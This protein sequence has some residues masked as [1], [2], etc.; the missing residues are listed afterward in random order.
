MAS[1]ER[2][3]CGGHFSICYFSLATDSLGILYF[4]FRGW[5]GGR[6]VGATLVANIANRSKSFLSRFLLDGNCSIRNAVHHS[7]MSCHRHVTRL[8]NGPG[9]RLRCTSLNSSV[10]LVRIIDGIHPSRVCGLTTR[11]R[12][13]IDFSTPR[14][15][16]GMSTAN[17]LHVLR[18]M[19]L[20]KLTSAYRVCRTSASRL[21][22]GIRRMPRGR[23]APFRPCDPC[24]MTGLCN[25]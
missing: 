15:A 2:H 16:T 23:G 20:Y 21:C 11:D 3:R 5:L 7:S 9:F 1:Q 12:I 6:S 17:I 8:R 22:N 14:F 24:T 4:L 19:H 10:D 13:R 18:T 25:R